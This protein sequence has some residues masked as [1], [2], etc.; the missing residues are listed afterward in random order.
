MY[1]Y[2]LGIFIKTSLSLPSPK[3]TDA[4]F[5]SNVTGILHASTSGPAPEKPSL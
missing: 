1:M 3:N 2:N 4:A 5:R